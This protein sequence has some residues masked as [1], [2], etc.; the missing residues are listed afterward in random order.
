MQREARGVVLYLHPEIP[1]LLH[2]GGTNQC[3]MVVQVGGISTDPQVNASVC[4]FTPAA[5]REPPQFDLLQM[6]NI[7]YDTYREISYK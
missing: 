4:V 6:C 3:V 5:H 2:C 7:V 1:L